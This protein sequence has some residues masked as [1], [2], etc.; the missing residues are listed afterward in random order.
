[1]RQT[2]IDHL[3]PIFCS[4]HKQKGTKIYKR[5][6][7]SREKGNDKSIEVLEEEEFQNFQE[8]EDEEMIEDDFEKENPQK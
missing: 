4:T 5:I 8:E 7:N 2:Q 6:R 3:I 1:M